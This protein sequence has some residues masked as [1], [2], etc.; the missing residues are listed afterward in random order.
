MGHL[1]TKKGSKRA[2]KVLSLSLILALASMLGLEAL[3]AVQMG[4][5][6]SPSRRPAASSDMLLLISGE[7]V[8]LQSVNH[9]EALEKMNSEILRQNSDV[10]ISHRHQ[11]RWQEACLE[12]NENAK[13]LS[14]KSKI[15]L[16]TEAL[17]PKIEKSLRDCLIRFEKKN[18]R[19]LKL[20]PSEKLSTWKWREALSALFARK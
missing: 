19:W 10:F 12:I 17:H 16:V 13:E 7:D 2:S 18:F 11:K 9:F 20:S 6:E 4:A 1:S 5:E 8:D 15:F 3:H 14:R